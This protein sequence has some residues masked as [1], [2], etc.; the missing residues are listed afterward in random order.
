MSNI[1][2]GI[3]KIFKKIVQSPVFKVVAIAVAVYFT[4]GIAAGAMGIS[5][6]ASLPGITSAM[7]FLGI[8]AP[9]IAEAGVIALEAAAPIQAA[10]YLEAGIVPGMEGAGGTAALA[11][12]S[13]GGAVLES[14]GLVNEASGTVTNAIGAQPAPGLTELGL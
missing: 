3:G 4:A 9:L 8:E 13:G 12:L 6:A 14:A 10:S 1:L 2:S 5:G 11:D 7:G